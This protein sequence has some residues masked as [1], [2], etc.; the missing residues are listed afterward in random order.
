LKGGVELASM[1]NASI[2]SIDQS[3]QLVPRPKVVAEKISTFEKWT[4][5]FIIFS[6]IYL[7]AHP[8]SIYLSIYLSKFYKTLSITDN[9]VSAQSG[10]LRKSRINRKVRNR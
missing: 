6:K 8:L 4:D 5:A 3:G 2:L 9:Y 7:A 1:Q 10:R